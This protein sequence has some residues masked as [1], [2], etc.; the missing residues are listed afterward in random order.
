MHR[1]KIQK[2]IFSAVLLIGL[3]GSSQNKLFA[4]E[5]GLTVNVKNRP[6]K[7][8]F[9]IIEKQ[10]QFVFI[11]K[12]NEVDV[13]RS[14]TTTIN[15]ASI[16]KVLN[17][18]F[19]GSDVNYKVNNLQIILT[20]KPTIT[21]QP[22]TP[23][24]EKKISGTITDIK[25]EPIIGANIVVKG[26]TSGIISDINGNFSILVP[27]Q[28]S[29]LLI[30][31]IG[32]NSKEVAVGNTNFLRV[33]LEEFTATM[34]E[35]IVVGY[36]SQ[37]KETL[38]GSIAQAT[39]ESLMRAGGVTNLAQTLTGQLPGVTTLQS[40]AQPG[41]DNPTIFIRGQ[42]TWN[43]GQPL[44]LVDGVERAMNDVDVNEVA[45]V[46]VLKDASATAVFGVKGADGVI[47]ITTKRGKIGKPQFSI[48]A[49]STGKTLSRLPNTLNAYNTLLLR[50]KGIER[51]VSSYPNAWS[52]YNPT[53]YIENYNPTN[54]NRE[55]LQWMYPDV[56]WKKVLIKDVG[57]SHRMNFGVSGGTEFAK[58][59]GSLSYTHDGDMMNSF[60]NDL[61]DYDP[62]YTYDR[63]NFRSNL[64]FQLTPT[65][66]FSI[67]LSGYVG[68][69]KMAGNGEAYQ[70]RQ[71]FAAYLR[72][73]V[74]LIVPRFPDGMYGFSPAWSDM[75]PFAVLNSTGVTTNNRTQIA[76]DFTFNQKLDFV[77][78]GLLFKASL[79]YDNYFSSTGN[80]ITGGNGNTTFQMKRMLPDG[81]VEYMQ[82]SGT[83]GYQYIIQPRSV[84][85]EETITTADI[86][87]LQQALVYEVSLNY[88]RKFN[89]HDISALALFKRRENST[90]S[91][92]PNFRED[93]VG[94]MTYNYDARYMMEVNAAYN[95]S[96][97]F[98]PGYRFGLFP[99]LA[100]GWLVSNE[101]F[102][103][104]DWLNKFK[105][106]G[107]IGKVGND[108]GIPRWSYISDWT[109]GGNIQMGTNS[110][111]NYP[112]TIYK[113]SVIANPD[114]HW[115][116]AIKR[117]IG[118]ELSL[119]KD[120]ISV[121]FD[122]FKDN[123][124]GIF[125]SGSQRSI[126]DFFGASP[127]AANLGKTTTM[128]YELEFKI[129][130]QFKNGLYLWA[131][132]SLTHSVDEVIYKED[133]ELLPAYQKQ[134][135]FQ[136]GQ[137]K[138]LYYNSVLQ[139]WD[140]VYSSVSTAANLAY[141]LPGDYNTVD[142][143]ADGVIDQ[144]DVVPVGYPN[145]PQNT[146]NYSFGADYKGWSTMLQF[147]AINNVSRSMQ[148]TTWY[149]NNDIAF[150]Y[151]LDYWTKENGSQVKEG[152]RFLSP[153]GHPYES[154]YDGSYIR[155]K[156]AEIAYTFDK[157]MLKHFG[158]N[159]LKLFFNGNNLIFWSKL[160]DDKEG[161]DSNA[162]STDYPLF[163]Q[164]NLG[165]NI[166]L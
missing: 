109:Y 37:K 135:G 32:Y 123:R 122:V 77:T 121:N 87:K 89:K 143:N 166:T 148:R 131:D 147:Y 52:F 94:R 38:V 126:L 159:S 104:F 36:G 161:A 142:Y 83:N 2:W 108:A 156:T 139:N 3:I 155:L 51:E 111:V 59:F 50:N 19:S 24:Q 151:D 80:N 57:M 16:D 95:G 105:I 61:Y 106:R 128:G 66:Q 64:D 160:K 86:N 35:V 140:D 69:Q 82:K 119:Y 17:V 107:S 132:V 112:Y 138:K 90:G 40:S 31:Y 103:K 101:S 134:A 116:T 14:I 84:N 12:S 18:I 154:L 114:L 146:Y 8:V 144:Y 81:T 158:F 100:L 43:G 76:S 110:V 4:A 22:S 153:F 33:T 115:E 164:F 68:I 133:P 20:K 136:I 1:R 70:Q 145:R 27:D 137:I 55:S 60:Y 118:A 39:G 29:K 125:L 9:T 49:N 67:N 45:S 11:Y 97:K 92:F 46:S 10:S 34:N 13:N 152:P 30:S 102:M 165:F 149:L 117:N 21:P 113:E 79:S 53:S 96:E 129:N 48:S 85:S 120:L 150:D 74:D 7:E 75:N 41:N 99:S 63:F 26:T 5:P 65:T 28:Q 73:P 56:D 162:E 47:L 141:R 88:A 98:G 127:V 15:N 124:D 72:N 54:P 42:S 157:K 91:V 78:K 71:I 62:G 58:Y 130:K 25:G 6:L 44:I 163:K 93:W 23:R